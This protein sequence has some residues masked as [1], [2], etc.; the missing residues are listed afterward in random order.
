MKKKIFISFLAATITMVFLALPVLAQRLLV[1]NVSS[2]VIQY[3]MR[4]ESLPKTLAPG[5]NG[6]AVYNASTSSGTAEFYLAIMQGG[7]ITPLGYFSKQLTNGKLLITDFDTKKI[8]VKTFEALSPSP[9]T[10][11][12]NYF[13]AYN[14]SGGSNLINKKLVV[15]EN[16]TGHRMVMLDGDFQGAAPA[17]HKKSNER[18]LIY[19]GL[20][21]YSLLYDKDFDSTSTGKNYMQAV[22]C[23]ILSEGDTSLTIK[24]TDLYFN[25]GKPTKIVLH[26]LLGFKFYFVGST[27]DGV[28]MSPGKYWK[29]KKVLNYGPNSFSIQFFKD[30]IKYQ[31]NLEIIITPQDKILDVRP[32]DVKNAQVIQGYSTKR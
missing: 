12:Q 6:E 19:P 2:S 13:A 30:G 31:A 21:M 20:K 8:G 18:R 22:F 3:R 29:G 26:S 16:G 15:L 10:S 27:F 23:K 9:V 11:T 4:G 25:L 1:S 28:A 24:E 32:E 17:C 5:T 14:P 7:S